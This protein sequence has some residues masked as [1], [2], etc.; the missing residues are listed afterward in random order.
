[1]SETIH[2]SA[3]EILRRE[4]RYRFGTLLRVVEAKLRHRLL[5]GS[6]SPEITR[7]ACEQGRAA[8]VVAHDPVADAVLLVRQF[9]FPALARRSAADSWLLEIPAGLEDDDETLEDVARREVLEETGYRLDGAL[10]R[11]CTV[12]PSPGLS[13]EEL[14]LFYATFSAGDRP[15]RGGGAD[16]E[17]EDIEVLVLPVTEAFDRLRRGEIADAKTVLGLQHLALRRAA[18]SEA[19]R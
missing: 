6:M 16:G 8:A 15:E 5:D 1:M 3:I 9:R 19:G 14:H 17:H 13:S 12:F 4:E 18:A 11:V 2:D 7:I 10:E